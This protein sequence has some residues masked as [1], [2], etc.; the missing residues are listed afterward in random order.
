ML[1]AD[2][3]DGADESVESVLSVLNLSKK[4]GETTA[5]DSISFDVKPSDNHAFDSVQAHENPY[6]PHHLSIAVEN[7]SGSRWNFP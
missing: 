6:N 5:V 7:R 1:T 2:S 4:Y 3:A